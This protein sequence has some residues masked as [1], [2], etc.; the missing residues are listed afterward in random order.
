MKL[1]NKQ[2]EVLSKAY[3][4]Y[5]SLDIIKNTLMVLEKLGDS[6]SYDISVAKFAKED[7]RWTILL[8]KVE[9]LND[10]YLLIDIRIGEQVAMLCITDMFSSSNSLYRHN[11][12][13]DFFIE[14]VNLQINLGRIFL[15]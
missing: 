13:I 9:K 14:E 10:K 3:K 7:E 6:N 15:S 2:I 11:N 5:V 8:R 12:R 1:I 4:K